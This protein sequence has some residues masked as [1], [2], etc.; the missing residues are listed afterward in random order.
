M[1]K[2]LTSQSNIEFVVVNKNEYVI[3]TKDRKVIL[4]GENLDDFEL[5][6]WLPHN[7]VQYKKDGCYS[8][9]DLSTNSKVRIP[10]LLSHIGFSHK[11]GYFITNRKFIVKERRSVFDICFFNLE[12]GKTEFFLTQTSLIPQIFFTEEESSMIGFW[13]HSIVKKISLESLDSIWEANLHSL[14]EIRK[15][16]GVIG[17][18]LWVVMYRGGV[19]Q[20]KIRLI[21]LNVNTGERVIELPDSLPLSEAHIALIEETQTILS[22]WGKI[23]TVSKADSPLVEIDGRT[24][25]VI[26]NHRIDSLYEAN[27]KMGRWIY[28]TGKVYFKAAMEFINSTHIGVMDYQSLDLLWFTEVKERKAGLRDFQVTSDKIFVLDQGHQ[29]HIYGKVSE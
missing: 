14:G 11:G 18:K 24:G 21:A 10:Q 6:G 3:N 9:L 13:P 29:L 23:S 28:K 19:D 4:N 25:E 27:L 26:R 8:L 1:Y 2:L 5:Y 7:F 20:D 12:S 22:I 16:L 15:I 17:D